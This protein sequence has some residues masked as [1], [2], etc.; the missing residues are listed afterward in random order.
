MTK[1]SYNIL[2]LKRVSVKG[3]CVSLYRRNIFLWLV[4]VILVL[5]HFNPPYLNMLGNVG[6]V[7]DRWRLVSLLIALLLFFNK[8]LIPSKL[9]ILIVLQ[10]LFVTFVTVINGGQVKDVVLEMG[11]VMAVILL[12]EFFMR[13]CNWRVFFSAVL[14]CF[15]SMICINLITVILYPHGMYWT[16]SFRD[17]FFVSWKCWFLGYYNNLTQF[18][19]PAYMFALLYINETKK[20]F[21][22]YML[23]IV[24]ALSAVY[25]KSGGVTISLAAIT[26][27]LVLFKNWTKLFNYFTYWLS[28]VV[29]LFFSIIIGL[30]SGFISWALDE[31]LGKRNS[32]L[33]RVIL[34]GRYARQ[35]LLKPILGYGV[36]HIY[37]RERLSG[38]SWGTHAH[39]FILETLYR[40]GII[41]LILWAIIIIVAGRNIFQYKDRETCKIIAA[42]F[43]GWCVDSYVEPF[44]SPFLMGMFIVAY[45]A[46][47]SEDK[48]LTRFRLHALC[49]NSENRMLSI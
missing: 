19:I 11:S 31:L 27:I 48:D 15:E 25:L 5:P 35:I 33:G 44:M 1:F 17:T 36:P 29:F 16:N 23:F 37:V 14:F 47:L 8:N 3:L 6:A 28:Q 24:M 45:F 32:Y 38:M 9:S 30:Y 2:K 42:C 10:R 39:N 18:L 13:T 21:R 34:W 49:R 12:F 22:S 40:G 46:G 20:R 26:I 41:N 7:I 4:I 43:G